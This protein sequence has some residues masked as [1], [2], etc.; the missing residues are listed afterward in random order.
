LAIRG[1]R[2]RSLDH[3]Q[4]YRRSRPVRIGNN[5]IDQVQLD[6]YGSVVFG[7]HYYAD[8]G[9]AL[10][11]VARRALR[12][13]GQ[14]VCEN[15][16]QPDSGLWEVPGDQRHYVHSKL[17]CWVALNCLI[18]MHEA[19]QMKAPV[20]QYR[21]ERA[22]IANEIETRGFNQESQSYVGI[23]DQNELDASVLQMAQVGYKDAR[24]ARI[25]STYEHIRREL[26]RD[27]LLL[28]YAPGFD[29]IPSREGTFGICSFWAVE[30]LALQGKMEEANSLFERMLATCND[31]GLMSEEYDPATGEALGNFPQTYTHAGLI[32]AALALRQAERKARSRR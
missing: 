7:A 19:G 5:A 27:G 21:R 11:H 6:V 26:G 23:L 28:R 20:D 32:T 10:D 13:F 30:L 15:W 18:K 14:V 12:Q 3:L 1:F 2:N 22:A 9:G 16:R 25:V 24:D 29:K 31:V 4:G 17:M 8:Q